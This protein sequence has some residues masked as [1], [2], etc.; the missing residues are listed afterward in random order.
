MEMQMP[1]WEQR[2]VYGQLYIKGSGLGLESL[3][4]D[5]W[6]QSGGGYKEVIVQKFPDLNIN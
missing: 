3:W 1:Y 2:E 6:K 4:T 5:L